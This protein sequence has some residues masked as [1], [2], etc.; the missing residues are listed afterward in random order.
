[1]ADE[2]SLLAQLVRI[3]NFRL[4]AG[5]TSSAD[6]L[7]TKLVASLV[8]AGAVSP[9]NAAQLV[10]AVLQQIIGEVLALGRRSS[11]WA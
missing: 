1:M 8:E 6:G 2:P 7:T 10:D 4:D 11:G 5:L 9:D 3:V